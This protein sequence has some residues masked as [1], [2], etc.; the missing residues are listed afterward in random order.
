MA[1][2]YHAAKENYVRHI[3]K[4]KAHADKM[5]E[6]YGNKGVLPEGVQSGTKAKLVKTAKENSIHYKKRLRQTK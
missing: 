4:A 3:T 2:K 5:V 1:N 6:K